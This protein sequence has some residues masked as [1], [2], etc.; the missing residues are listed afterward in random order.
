MWIMRCIGWRWT[1]MR[2]SRI[3]VLAVGSFSFSLF[4]FLCILVRFGAKKR[5]IRMCSN[6]FAVD[7]SMVF[8]LDL[9]NILE[10]VRGN[11][12]KR[13]TTWIT[14]ELGGF[15][16]IGKCIKKSNFQFPRIQWGRPHT[17]GMGVHFSVVRALFSRSIWFDKYCAIYFRL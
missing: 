4:W 15:A 6:A 14:L 11:K 8:L 17:L 5:I 10:N 3:C 2:S 9:N 7:Y 13:G 1:P 16:F 12:Y